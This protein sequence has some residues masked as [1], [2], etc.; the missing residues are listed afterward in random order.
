MILKSRSIS[1]SNFWG[2][3][4]SDS[5]KSESMHSLHW[6]DLSGE[7]SDFLWNLNL[8]RS[9]LWNQDI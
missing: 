1:G 6:W 5:W 7:G 9:F 8:R 2:K 3:Y 4:W